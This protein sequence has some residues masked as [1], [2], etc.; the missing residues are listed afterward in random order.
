MLIRHRKAS[1][2][3]SS[4]ITP[5]GRYLNRRTFI[6]AATGAAVALSAGERLARA[7]TLPT[8]GATFANVK[9][10]YAKL[11]E[12]DAVTPHDSATTYNNYYEFAQGKDQPAKL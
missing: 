9:L 11:G 4:E 10:G 8:A 3:A 5:E 7:G 1:E 6:S 2:A 12:D